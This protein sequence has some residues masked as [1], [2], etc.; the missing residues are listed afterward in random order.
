MANLFSPDYQWLWTI[1]LGLALFWPIRNLIWVL[2]VRREQART[3][4]TPDEARRRALK[5]RAS[6]TAGLLSFVFA[7]IYVQ[8]LFGSLYGNPG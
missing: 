1:V 3:G 7:V 6:V 4:D 2:S 5:M 8:V